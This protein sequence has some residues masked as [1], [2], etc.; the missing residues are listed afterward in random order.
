LDPISLR[1]RGGGE[2][3][4]KKIAVRLKRVAGE[5][6]AFPANARFASAEMI[7]PTKRAR[8]PDHAE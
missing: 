8:V 1:A 4:V 6:L 7:I 2:K 5:W 3:A